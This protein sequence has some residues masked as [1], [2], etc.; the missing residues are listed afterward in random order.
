MQAAAKEIEFAIKA[1]PA[2]NHVLPAMFLTADIIIGDAKKKFVRYV[3]II[4]HFAT[5]L[6][7]ML[8]NN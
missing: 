8:R 5:A 1:F 7:L 3:L 4:L 2:I 6:L